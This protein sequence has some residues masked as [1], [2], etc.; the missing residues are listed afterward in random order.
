MNL[1]AFGPAVWTWINNTVFLLLPCLPSTW[2]NHLLLPI[3]AEKMFSC[4]EELSSADLTRP[5]EQRSCI[6]YHSRSLSDSVQL[7]GALFGLYF[8]PR[9]QEC[10]TSVQFT[11]FQIVTKKGQN[12]CRYLPVHSKFKYWVIFF[13]INQI[14]NKASRLALWRQETS[15]QRN[16]KKEEFGLSIF[17]QTGTR[18]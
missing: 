15:L 10:A 12:W 4:G 2:T 1:R 13:W 11:I 16:S 3:F 14:S 8:F 7:S 9:K 6:F 5:D 17:E 18:L